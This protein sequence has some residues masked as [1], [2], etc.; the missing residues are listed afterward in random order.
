VNTDLF[1]PSFSNPAGSPIREL[2][3]YLGR[4]GMISFAGGY[5]SPSL[6]DAEGLQQAT[7]N[8]MA[9]GAGLLQ[10]GAT[11]G[12]PTLREELLK[13]SAA[14]GIVARPEQL[15]VTTGSQQAFDLLVRIFVQP[16]D[17][18]LIESPAYPAAIQ[19][20]RLA[21]AQ[22]IEVPM[23]ADGLQTSALEALLQSQPSGTRPKLLYTVPTFS[24]PRGTL[25]TQERRAQLVR[26]ASQHGFLVIEDDPYGELAF[27]GERAEPLY[28]HGE[29]LG[30]ASN[31]VIYLSSLSK[32]V[33]PALRVGWMIASPD[34]VRR[35]TVAKQT[36]DLCTSPI[37]QLIA[38]EYLRSGRYP[39][40]VRAACDEYRRRSE[41]MAGTLK[42]TL[43]ERIVLESPKGGMFLWA[44]IADEVD[45]KAVFQSAVDKGVLFVPGA[46]FHVAPPKGG[47]MRLS[48][49]AP[50]VD[51]IRE[52]VS[53]LAR[54]F[55]DCSRPAG[56]AQPAQP[57]QSARAQ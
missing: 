16:G 24:N 18:V 9:Q 19:A 30:G 47:S 25:L 42:E 15:L 46:A 26:L 2:F 55:D 36:V 13:L 45:A 3:P 28:V 32:T 20:L 48:F 54:A 5:P 1:V 8:V 27:T 43:G 37:A 34:I 39:A 44:G 7:A 49:A 57:A 56:T 52:G 31:P 14:R 35:S 23:D 22:L 6:F 38:A 10:Y 53:R 50:T 41:A 51:Q 4:P 21:G 17:A 29:R 40:T 33:A 11:E 12:V